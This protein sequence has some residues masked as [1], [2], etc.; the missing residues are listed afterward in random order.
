MSLGGSVGGVLPS[1]CFGFMFS[2]MWRFGG[3][4]YL[5]IQ[6]SALQIVERSYGRAAGSPAGFL[7]GL[8]CD[9]SGR[10]EGE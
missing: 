6:D 10:K 4:S 1:S 3:I 8:V 9:L 5:A 2:C 7:G